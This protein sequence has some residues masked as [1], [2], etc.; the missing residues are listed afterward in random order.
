MEDDTCALERLFGQLAGL[1]RANAVP[2]CTTVAAGFAAHMYAFTNKLL[3]ADELTAL[4]SKGGSMESGRW[5][6]DIL[7]L[8]FPNVSMPWIY[9][10]ISIL[11]LSVS[12]CLT[13]RIFEIKSAALQ[14]G[15]AAVIAAF[16]ALT[17][18][19]CYIFTSSSFMLSLLLSVLA[20]YVA[21]GD[22]ARRWLAGCG[23]MVLS[24]GIYQAYVAVAASFFVLLMVRRLLREEGSPG[25]VFRFGLSRAA[26]LLAA[27]VVYYLISVAVLKIAGRSFLDYG[28]EQSSSL[29][30][31]LRLV[32]TSFLGTFI[33]GN[34]GY[35]NSPLSAA[36]HIVC[37][38]FTLAAL[39]VWFVKTHDR[40]RKALMLLCLLIFPVSTN[41]IYLIAEVGIIHSLVMFSFTSVYVLAA[42]AAENT[43]WRGKPAFKNSLLAS[44]LLISVGNMYFSNKV[45]LKMAI[46]YENAYA[47]YTGLAAQVKMTE[48]FEEGTKLAL[49]GDAEQ[50]L[51]TPE[52]LD[53]G[54][55]LGPSAD[56]IN[57]YTREELIKKYVGFNV[58]FASAKEKTDLRS[59]ER[60]QEMPVYPYYGSVKRIDDFIVV[61]LSE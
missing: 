49:V 51:Y 26:L 36:L 58:P 22:G 35:V 31:R 34:Y 20:V 30:Y 52:E 28:V 46:Q 18:T 43:D 33:K 9:G 41:C 21:K 38:M 7:P 1:L 54:D 2:F 29:L 6:L 23:L 40:G 27:L 11:L 5:G 39:A 56:L 15:L 4:F 16:P 25:E 42:V 37:A 10:L 3:N 48:G 61:K 44:L 12:V 59:D 19:F 55:L 14:A 24:L 47:F 17:G 60:F 45:Y 53:T 32:F 50:L 8:I 13:V 57:V